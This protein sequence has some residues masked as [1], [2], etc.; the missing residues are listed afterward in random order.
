MTSPPHPEGDTAIVGSAV[1]AR[2]A[3]DPTARR[4]DHGGAPGDPLP[5]LRVV[6][7]RPR[8]ASSD[9]LSAQLWALGAQG[10]WERPD[11]LVAWFSPDTLQRPEVRDAPVLAAARIEEEP[12]RDWQAEW[13]A[14][15]GPV[16]AGRT[17]V[18]PSWLADD[19]QAEADELTLVLDPGRAFGSGHHATTLLCLEVLDELARDG[20]LEELRVADVGCGSGILALAAAARG[21]VVQAVDIDPAA[22][23]VTSEN[24]A[25]N[26]ITLE[27]RRG[28]VDAVR[29]PVDLVVANLITDVVAELA[30]PLVRASRDRLVLSG[31]TEE[32][33]RTALEPL[34]RAGAT[35]EDLRTRDG[36]IVAV[37]R[38]P[39]SP[40]APGTS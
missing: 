37:L 13:K 25:R 35:L 10:V 29:P 39:V 32:R 7:E 36:W 28:S 31:I 23:A 16:R 17:V 30:E 12:D 18:V 33:Q 6:V 21:A 38:A 3:E 2:P 9:L 4:A 8:S 15:I 1:G 24:A 27:V 11:D 34:E 19:H 20:G 26:G 5:T 40:E 14:T 22:V